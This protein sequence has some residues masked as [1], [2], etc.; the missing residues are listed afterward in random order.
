MKRM[1]IT[2]IL[3]AAVLMLSGCL[4]PEER[5]AENQV[6]YKEQLQSVQTAVNKF[7]EDNDGILPIKT[8][9]E[10]TPIYIKYPID[11]NRLKP[12]YIADPP[13]NA[14]E[15]GGIFQYVLVD[16]ENNPTV[17]IFDLRMAE[18]IR[19]LNIRLQTSKYPPFKDNVADHV[20]SLDY[21]KLGYKKEPYV[22]SPFSQRNLSLVIS[23]K[24]ELYVDYSPDLYE[25][26]KSK[27]H[28]YK[29]GEDIREILLEDSD[30]VPAYSLP[31]TVN[32][33]NEPVF[34][35]K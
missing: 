12:Q 25:K 26:L 17:K 11:F 10:Q 2:G 9:D 15:S 22:V 16:V 14:F 28:S 6:P 32:E 19:S 8:R 21:S 35:A 24:G 34:M 31:Y 33:K 4:Y 29:P 18:K 27:K 30:F 20:F 3:A 1:M 13:G 23:G 5:K 7:R